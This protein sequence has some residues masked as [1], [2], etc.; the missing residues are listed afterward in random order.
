MTKRMFVDG[1][2]VTI[3]KPGYDAENP[4]AL[5]YRYIAFDSRMNR[6]L[7]LEIGLIPGASFNFGSVFNYSQAYVG[8]PAIDIIAYGSNVLGPVYNKPIAIRDVGSVE[9]R[10]TSFYLICYNDRFQVVDDARYVRTAYYGTLNLY[11][12]L[13][14]TW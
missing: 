13:W 6:G 12:V 11:Y 4:P 10:R 3:T 1:S 8:I 2:R 14:Q 5:D 7:P 9:F